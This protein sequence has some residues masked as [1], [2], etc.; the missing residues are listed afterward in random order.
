MRGRK[1]MEQLRSSLL[2]DQSGGSKS[3]FLQREER[4]WK[5]RRPPWW[6]PMQH[7]SEKRREAEGGEAIWHKLFCHVTFRPP[8]PPPPPPSVVCLLLL[9]S[10]FSVGVTLRPPLAWHDSDP[11]PPFFETS[12][13]GGFTVVRVS[14]LGKRGEASFLLLLSTSANQGRAAIKRGRKMRKKKKNRQIWEFFF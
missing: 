6:N 7:D 13:K 14:S 10:F 4:E 3:E 11:P 1:K 12:R 9:P 2:P 8:F 5:R